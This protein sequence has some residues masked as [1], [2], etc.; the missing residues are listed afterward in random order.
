MSPC[1]WAQRRGL[2]R[3]G[4]GAGR[5]QGLALVW[6]GWAWPQDCPWLTH[7][8]LSSLMLQEEEPKE[9]EKGLPVVCTEHLAPSGDRPGWE[10]LTSSF[11]LVFSVLCEIG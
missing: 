9:I 10:A 7:S 4:A 5:G 3:G 1:P 11:H 6:D 8:G 2:A